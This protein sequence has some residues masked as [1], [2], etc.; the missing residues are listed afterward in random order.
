MA[1]VIAWY[2]LTTF[3]G[4]VSFPLVYRLFPKLRDHGYSVSR[5]IGLLVWGYIFWLLTSLG[6]L[7]NN[8]AGLLFALAIL[9]GLSLWAYRGIERAEIKAWLRTNRGAILAI[10]LLFLAVFAGWS[11][12]RAYNPEAVGTEKP[13][14][15]A[16]I[17]AIINSPTFP[18][19]DAWLSGYAISYYYFGYVLVAMLAKITAVAGSVA[20]NLGLALVFALTAIGAFGLVYNL[21]NAYRH[22]D[23]DKSARENN[24]NLIASFLGPLFVLIVSNLEGFLQVLHTRGVLWQSNA[25][26]QLTSAFWRWLDIKDLNQPPEMPLSWIPQRFW[27]WW[28]ASRVLQDYDLSGVEKEIIDEFPFFSFLLGDLHPHVL[29]MPF[30]LLALALALNVLLGGGRGRLDWFHYRISLRSLARIDVISALAGALLLYFGVDRMS[31]GLAA[32]SVLLMTLSITI[33]VRLR[34][35]LIEHKLAILIQAD[36]DTITIGRPVGLN[37]AAFLIA[38]LA[39]GGMFFL[40]AWDFPVYVA[41]FAAAYALQRLMER[42]GSFAHALGDFFW[43]GITLGISGVLL[44]LPFYVSFSSQAGGVLP[45][46]I[47]PTRGAHLWVMFAP[48]LIPLFAFIFHLR[49]QFKHPRGLSTGISL[50]IGFVLILFFAALFMGFAITLIPQVNSLFLSTLG[51]INS[52]EVFGAVFTRRLTNTGGWITLSVLLAFTLA[53]LRG[54]EQPDPDEKS[55]DNPE[56]QAVENYSQTRA[57]S[58]TSDSRIPIAH[59]FALLLILLG[60]LMVFGPEFFFLRDQFGWRMNT[61]FKFYFQSWLLWSIAAAYS[62][63]VL[64]REL[65]G[66]SGILFRVFWFILIAASL[67]YPPLSLVSKTSG[68][69]A[70]PT[71]DSSAYLETQSPDEWAALHWLQAAPPG[72]IA[73]AVPASGGSYTQYARMATLSGK[74]NVLGWVGHQSQWRGGGLEMGTRKE[75]LALL[76]CTRLWEEARLVLDRYNVRYIIVGPLERSAYQPE[77]GICN[78]GLVEAKFIRN[79]TPVFKQGGVTIYEYSATR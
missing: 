22:R 13:M 60:T 28:R 37:P 49:K 18:P 23:T 59:I 21:L 25:E 26:G 69:S 29:A 45:N 52:Q 64:M 39:L 5:V 53:V 7:R 20:F 35:A 30:A 14:E 79:L 62:S 47:Y 36:L 70:Q 15:L 31:L 71:L 76:Y 67:V 50:T 34:H 55:I 6:A 56:E 46:L 72:I 33:T 1:S 74:P 40:N 58:K 51:T 65:R 17:N 9:V 2:L 66:V 10:E 42:R 12:V 57:A 68:F 61:I 4:W 78:A 8:V 3:L 43:I 48:L 24:G 32:A 19:H 27:W 38:S 77:A 75:D 41:L 63:I 44:Y 16:F 11:I 73:E 54:V